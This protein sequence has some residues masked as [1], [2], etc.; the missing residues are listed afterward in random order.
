[1]NPIRPNRRSVILTGLALAIAPALPVRAGD[2]AMQVAKDPDCGCCADWVAILQEAGFAV[3][4]E[5]MD[6]AALQDRKAAAGIPEAMRSC[7]TGLIE[8]YAVEGHVPVR[9][10]LRLLDER[11]EAVGLAVPGMPFGS[12]GMGPE[13]QREAYDVFLIRADGSSEVFAS[14]AA[15]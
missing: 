5:E 7:H 9:D 3:S 15:A 8:G 4:V 11:P 10:I 13:D 12:P 6:P 2:L 14:Y 1:M